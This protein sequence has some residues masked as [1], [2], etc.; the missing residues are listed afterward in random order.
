MVSVKYL[1]SVLILTSFLA[2]CAGRSASP[3]M[4]TQYNDKSMNCEQIGEEMRRIEV[5]IRSLL[6][7]SDK[8]A[9]RVGW[10]IAGLF[11]FPLWF[12]MDLSDAEK[13]EIDAYKSRYENLRYLAHE[14]CE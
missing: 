12:A 9:N 7:Q 11:F 13:I 10:G 3:V 4:A 2:A 5:E 14:K 6:P 8:T 1:L